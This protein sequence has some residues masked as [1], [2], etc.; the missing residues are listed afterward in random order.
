MAF[1]AI[2]PSL[3]AGEVGVDADGGAASFAHRE[4]H[5][6]G[7]EHD[8]ASGENAGNRGHVGLAID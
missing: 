8:V 7:A 2:S 1:R 6:G 3:T 4:N 5:R